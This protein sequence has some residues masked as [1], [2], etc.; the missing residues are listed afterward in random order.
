MDL[1]G[2]WL[3]FFFHLGLTLF[4]SSHTEFIQFFSMA[5]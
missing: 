4:I 3:L 2:A 5:C 1:R